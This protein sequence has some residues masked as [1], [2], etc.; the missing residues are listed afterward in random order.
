LG[1]THLHGSGSYDVIV[2]EGS[3]FSKEFS[4]GDVFF[5]NLS[6]LGQRR[7]LLIAFGDVGQSGIRSGEW[8]SAAP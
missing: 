2:E 6:H 7:P 8:S 5:M 1:I 3:S 4:F